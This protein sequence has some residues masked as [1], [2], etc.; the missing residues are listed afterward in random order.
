VGTLLT[1][2][3]VRGRGRFV[4]VLRAA[5][6]GVC[7]VGGMARGADREWINPKGGVFDAGA[8][9]SGG[10][11][12]GPDDNA[13]FNLSSSSRY[14]LTI[15]QN[16][17]LMWSHALLVRNDQVSLS[18]LPT[19]FW[20]VLPT[21]W[22]S[23]REGDPPFPASS[24]LI[25]VGQS[26]GEVGKLTLNRGQIIGRRATIGQGVGSSG[27]LV[28]DAQGQWNSGFDYAALYL[29]KLNDGILHVGEYGTGTLRIAGAGV[30]TSATSYI[31]TNAGSIGTATV[32]GHYST[33]DNSE[34]LYI[35]KLGQGTLTAESLAFVGA[36][37]IY[38][39]SGAGSRATV[40]SSSEADITATERVYIASGA[41]AS[42]SVTLNGGSLNAGDSMY[43]GGNETTAGGSASVVVGLGGELQ[44]GFKLKVYPGSTITLN[45]GLL[46]ARILEAPGGS[47][48]WNSGEL[49]MRNW[50]VSAGSPLT[51]GAGQTLSMYSDGGLTLLPGSTL[52]L[53]G[54]TLR[55]PEVTGGGTFS[56]TNG[57]LYLIRDVAFATDPLFGDGYTIG[58]GRKVG[59]YLGVVNEGSMLTVASGGRLKPSDL[60]VAG[61]LNLNGGELATRDLTVDSAGTSAGRV[62]ATQNAAITLEQYLYVGRTGKGSVVQDSGTTVLKRQVYLGYEAGGNGTYEL[63]GTGALSSYNQAIG[64]GGTGVFKQSGGTNQTSQVP[65][66]SEPAYSICLGHQTTGNGTYELSGGSVTAARTVVGRQGTGGFVQ[67]NGSATFEQLV[68]GEES[69]GRGSYEMSGGSLSL[70]V[71]GTSL[72]VGSKGVGTFTQ[73]SGAVLIGWHEYETALICNSAG[74]VGTYELRGGALTNSGI[75][76]VGRN[77]TGT[78]NQSGGTHTAKGVW[79]GDANASGTGTYNMSGGTLDAETITL[80]P[81][82]TFNYTGGTMKFTTLT[83]WGGSFTAAGTPLVLENPAGTSTYQLIGGTASFETIDLR[84]GGVLELQAGTFNCGTLN[85]MGG[86]IKGAFTNRGVYNYTSGAF[87]VVFVNQGTINLNSGRAVHVQDLTANGAVVGSDPMVVD[88]TISGTGSVQTDL[89]VA[90]RMNS[91]ASPGTLSVGGQYTQASG[92]SMIVEVTRPDLVG[93]GKKYVQQ[94]DL[95]AVSGEALL[96]GTL[97]IRLLDGFAP[98]EGDSYKIMSSGSRAGSFGN[99]IGWSAGYRVA[100]EPVFG[101]NDLSLVVR[102]TTDKQWAGGSGTWSE[103]GSWTEAGQPRM[104]DNVRLVQNGGGISTVAYSNSRYPST[105]L[106]E[107]HVDSQ[108]GGKMTLVQHSSEQ[109]S[110]LSIYVGK[111]GSGALSQ[112]SGEVVAA[113]ALYVGHEAGSSG[114][115]ELGDGRVSAKDEYVGYFGKGTFQQTGGE[116]VVAGQLGIAFFPQSSGSYEQ[117]AGYLQAKDI[118]NNGT[119]TQVGGTLAVG[120]SFTMTG[121][122][123]VLGGK[124]EWS[125]GATLSIYDGSVLVMNSDAGSASARRLIMNVAGGT[126]TFNMSQHLKRLSVW[127]TAVVGADGGQLLFTEGLM[128]DAVGKLDLGRNAMIVQSEAGKAERVLGS[129][130]E[131]IKGGR[132]VG[133]EGNAFAGLAGVLN[134]QGGGAGAV[135][136][137][138]AGESV[139]VN[140]VLVKYTWNGDAN[141]DGLVNADDYFLAD[142]GYVTQKGGWYNGDFNYDGVVNA[143]DYFLIDSAFIG[144][145]GVLAGMGRVA[146]VPEAGAVGMVV[147]LGMGMMGRRKRR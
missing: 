17:H 19:P 106:S 38:V 60:N 131:Y 12:P 31:A 108:G 80:N 146:A 36:K 87:P 136:N 50:T 14:A 101:S 98:K 81:G 78:F 82:G 124:Q 115:Y 95:V 34:S 63:S 25:V 120:K 147:L 94:N 44:G 109:L 100:F 24:H 35:G 102:K 16:S 22:A 58:A 126:A 18:L 113:Q 138:Y 112:G 15:D 107:L 139:D 129:I 7:L 49:V 13:I 75:I 30:V 64:F 48:I 46:G 43:I 8:N 56:F 119:F 93:P 9:W 74:S 71:S 45:G 111:T 20:Y 122:T 23:W 42:A 144:Q 5:C 66:H 128:I 135:F 21:N 125:D 51:V 103:D 40:V 3:V 92:S 84:S 10:V 79:V 127:D 41:G 26:S 65:T 141:L 11:A 143:D 77:G 72:V 37:N 121:G 142:S 68:L 59:A 61:M 83:Q 118:V 91:G 1:D 6:A 137:L 2:V 62:N 114:S 27:E 140:S 32:S 110:A 54:G 104:G 88:G 33:W 69:T 67:S 132:I 145:T 53:D 97:D 133:A 105:V 117:S 85:Q 28:V 96:G 90:G 52:I 89:T 134:G 116:H 123:A 76:K 39:A 4:S 70:S 29:D 73:T 86:A 55:V 130:V 47:I 57:F 99:V